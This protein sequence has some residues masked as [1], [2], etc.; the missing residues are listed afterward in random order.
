MSNEISW[1]NRDRSQWLG[2]SDAAAV[3]GLSP[4]KTPYDLWLE[5]TS[6]K[7]EELTEEKRRFFARRKRQEPVIAEMLAD[8]YNVEVSRLSISGNPNYYTDPDLPFMA[9]EID[10]EFPMSSKVAA[11][12]EREDFAMIPDGTIISG[13]LKTVSPFAAGEWGE[14]GS[15][16]VPTHYAAQVMHGLGI[17]KER[18]A[19]L[20]AAL[21]GLDKLSCFPVMRDEETITAMRTKSIAFWT[22]NVVKHIP[23]EPM[24]MEDIEKMYRA[25]KGRPANLSDAAYAALGKIQSIR[26]SMKALEQE[27]TEAQWAVARSVAMEWRAELLER[28]NSKKIAVPDLAEK[29]N[30]ILLH[31]GIAVGT[32]NSQAGAYLD[33]RRL[34]AEHPEIIAAYTKRHSYRVLRLKK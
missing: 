1:V 17:T 19:T 2:G 28:I 33:Q 32:W 9:A 6:G 20:L 7:Q 34:K 14:E 27:E 24:K 12:F 11:H 26:A 31:G 16:E 30:A 4:W 5:K 15:E 22:E 18:P 25:F 29:E 23:P 10:F 13:E 8:M 21:F 3:F